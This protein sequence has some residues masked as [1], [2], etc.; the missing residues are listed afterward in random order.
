[1]ESTFYASGPHPFCRAGGRHRPGPRQRCRGRASGY[2]RIGRHAA[3]Y[4][5]PA[6][7]CRAVPGRGGAARLRRPDQPSGKIA[8]RFADWGERLRPPGLRWS[9][10]T[11]SDRAGSVPMPRARSATCAPSRE[12]VADADAARRWLQSQSWAKQDRVS[13]ARLV[14]RRRSRR[15]GRCGRAPCRT[16]EPD[17]R[18][19]VA[20]YPGCRRLGT[21]AWSAR[22]PTLI[23]IG[24]ADDWTPAARLRTD[25]GGRARPQRACL[26]RGLSGRLSRIR[27]SR[28]P[29]A[30]AER[31]AYS[32]GRIRPRA[33]RHQCGRAPMHPTRSSACRHRLGD[34]GST[35]R[36]AQPNRLPWP[37]SPPWP[38]RGGLAGRS[39]ASLAV[40]APSASAR[41]RPSENSMSSRMPGRRPRRD[42][43][44][45]AGEVAHE[46][47]AA[48]Q[49]AAIGQR[50]QQLA[51]A[52][53]TRGRAGAAASPS[54]AARAPR[55]LRRAV[56][57]ARDA[58]RMRLA[59]W[60]EPARA[61]RGDRQP[62]AAA[63][64]P[65]VSA[66]RARSATRS[67]A[68]RSAD[69][70]AQPA[71]RAAR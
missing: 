68:R 19:A 69:A 65:S 24:R 62:L 11:A 38:A 4:L 33:Y 44:R 28:L 21:V 55:T 8:P 54:P 53:S 46:R 15:C 45:L 67:C 22:I 61:V 71:G 5:V 16:T 14:E 26:D 59:R 42:A 50:G 17:F 52:R 2:P 12:R 63:Q 70:G 66:R 49:H 40:A 41:T 37:S 9:F 13:A 58:G 20:F 6:G 23:L 3:R 29:G 48:R 64:P 1:M 34:G 47:K 31:L 7:R 27:S 10:P 18:S 57:R 60:H 43:Q 39:G 30:R 56:A 51:V 25:G 35:R 36:D 32:R